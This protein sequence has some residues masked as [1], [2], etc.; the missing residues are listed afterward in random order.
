MI[1]LLER[2]QVYKVIIAAV[3]AAVLLSSDY[4]YVGTVN[5]ADLCLERNLFPRILKFYF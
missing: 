2:L 1:P 5:F 4:D 3:V